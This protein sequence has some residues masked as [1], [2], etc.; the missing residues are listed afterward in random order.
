VLLSRTFPLDSPQV[1][2]T[3]ETLYRLSKTLLELLYCVSSQSAFIQS[4]ELHVSQPRLSQLIQV[5]E[6]QTSLPE[7][8]IDPELY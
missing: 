7:S 3:K 4:L 1:N 5:I 8:E 6:L 2:Q